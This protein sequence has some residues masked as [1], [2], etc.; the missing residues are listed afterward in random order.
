MNKYSLNYEPRNLAI[1]LEGGISDEEDARRIVACVNACAEISND[2]LET[3]AKHQGLPALD[4]MLSEIKTIRSQRDELLS[5]LE[6]LTKAALDH[7]KKGSH[8][9]FDMGLLRVQID[10]AKIV[11]ARVKEN[12]V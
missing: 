9:A 7:H 8:A 6:R 3:F 2:A 5:A 11:I 1:V 4:V 12:N 10:A